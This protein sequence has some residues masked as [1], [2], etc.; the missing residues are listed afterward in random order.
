VSD[1]HE[2]TS[3][4]G[5]A[6]AGARTR[7]VGVHHLNVRVGYPREDLAWIADE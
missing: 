7:K 6:D 5:G 2:E 1:A 4:R 3:A